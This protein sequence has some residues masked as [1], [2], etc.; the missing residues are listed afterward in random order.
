MLKFDF[1]TCAG[2]S[3]RQRTGL[4]IALTTALLI[5]LGALYLQLTAIEAGG[6]GSLVAGLVSPII[7]LMFAAGCF[8]L[9]ATPN[10]SEPKEVEG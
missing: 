6:E 7:L 1:Q 4:Y 5:Q 3:P 2:L 10:R 9:N 8:R